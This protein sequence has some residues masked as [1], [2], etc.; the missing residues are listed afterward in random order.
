VGKP[1]HSLL[2]A[3]LPA[4]F[5][6]SR[7]AGQLPPGNLVR[8]LAVLASMGVLLYLLLRRVLGSSVRA[9]MVTSIF[10]LWLFSWG[11]LVLLAERAGMWGGARRWLT[12]GAWLLVLA[13]AV[14][15]VVRTRRDLSP[16]TRF[17]NAAAALAV[18]FQVVT[19][20]PPVWRQ[21]TRQPLKPDMRGFRLTVRPGTRLPNIYWIV[22]DGY[23]RADVLRDS[24]GFDNREF[25]AFLRR[26]GFYVAE[27]SSANY[28]TTLLSLPCTLNMEYL[29]ALPRLVGRDSRDIAP[30]LGYTEHNRIVRLLRGA[31][32]R[33]VSFYCEYTWWQ[34]R[35]ADR[36]LGAPALSDFERLL[37]DATPLYALGKRE[38]WEQR[39]LR[40]QILYTLDHLAD[41]EDGRGPVFV[42][43]H[44]LCPHPPFVFGRRGELPLTQEGFLSATISAGRTPD[45]VWRRRYAEQV[46]YLNGLVERALTR[47]LAKTAPDTVIIVQGDHG[48]P[49]QPTRRDHDRE[50]LGILNAIRLPG[51]EGA[52]RPDLSPVNT[53]RL[54]LN[55]IFSAGLPLLPN[56]YYYVFWNRPYAFVE[57]PAATL[58][59]AADPVPRREQVGV[60]RS[61]L[62]G[63]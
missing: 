29:D 18:A 39:E 7:N 35:S 61:R 12:E 44:V 51:G 48:P 37:A 46:E 23:G 42:F 38:R 2:F 30:V 11:H 1:F 25:L 10:S 3:V 26:R 34:M 43:A 40:Q 5:L 15:L 63:P 36:Y 13:A 14:W 27:A 41:A 58:V 28:Y 33:I 4:L 24:F 52:L 32:Y 47:L 57:V 45:R 50:L 16:A 55:H 19:M 60:R 20:A 62:S 22:L 31:G 56:K 54:V 17:L 8:P 6:Y 49:R 53:F 21:V 9:A 59:P